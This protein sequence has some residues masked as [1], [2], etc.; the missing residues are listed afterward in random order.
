MAVWFDAFV[1]NVDRTPRNANLLCWHH[2]LYF[3]DHGASIYVHHDWESMLERADSPFREVKNHILLPWASDL[4][5]ADEQARLRLTEDRIAEILEAVPDKWLLREGDGLSAG[6]KRA[7]YSDFFARR[8][9]ASA[10]F[11]EEANRA[12]S[13]LV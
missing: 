1:M 3:I 5:E 2:E 7:V 4:G 10:R 8:L 6:E 12:R 13:E 11:V 9:K